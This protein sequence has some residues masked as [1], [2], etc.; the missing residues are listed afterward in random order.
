MTVVLIVVGLALWFFDA[1]GNR[2]ELI[3]FL[4]FIPYVLCGYFLTA[5]RL[6]DM[7][8]TGWLALLWIPVGIADKFIGGAASLAFSLF[9]TQFPEREATIAMALIQ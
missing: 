6:R 8:L 3:F 5:Q 2:G 9:F 7:N 4:F 1:R